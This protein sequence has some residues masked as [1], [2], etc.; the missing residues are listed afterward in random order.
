MLEQE[1]AEGEA[2]VA[3][4]FPRELLRV[5][6]ICEADA[7][8]PL[9]PKDV[10]FAA[11]D[12]LMEDNDSIIIEKYHES[13]TCWEEDACSGRETAIGQHDGFQGFI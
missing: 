3:A 12:N 11:V 6:D 13:G 10:I 7:K 9:Q 4:P 8:V 2:R 1:A 5:V